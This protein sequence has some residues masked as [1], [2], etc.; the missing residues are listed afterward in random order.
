MTE[1]IVFFKV[2]LF[3][4][5]LGFG[6]TCLLAKPFNNKFTFIFVTAPCIGYSTIAIMCVFPL[7][8]IKNGSITYNVQNWQIY[9]YNIL[10]GLSGLIGICYTLYI[11]L[12]KKQPF[13]LAFLRVN[14]GLVAMIFILVYIYININ[15]FHNGFFSQNV[16]PDAAAYLSSADWIAKNGT[17]TLISDGYAHEV[18]VNALRWGFPS[19]LSI[20]SLVLHI[21]VSQVIFPLVII[22]FSSCIGLM[23]LLMTDALS[24]SHKKLMPIILVA[25]LLNGSLLAFLGESFY[26]FVISIGYFSVF[27]SL[28]QHSVKSHKHILFIGAICT[29]TCVSTSSE[30][31]CLCVVLIFGIVLYNYIKC[32]RITANNLYLVF[33][34]ILGLILV[35]P[36]SYKIFGFTAANSANFNNIGYP[37]PSWFSPS[38]IIGLTN[39]YFHSSEYLNSA[40][41]I[42]N[43]IMRSIPDIVINLLFSMFVVFELFKW[44]KNVLFIVSL[45]I[46]ISVFCLDVYLIQYRHY[47]PY[48]Y[49]YDK[50]VIAFAPIFIA[51][52][53]ISIDKSKKYPNIKFVISLL[54]IF[55]SSALFFHDRKATVS[56]VDIDSLNLIKMKLLGK[57]AVIFTDS[58]GSRNGY[59]IGKFRYIDRSADI[60]SEVI[61]GRN[62][63]D[64]WTINCLNYPQN[65]EVY[66]IVKKS[67]FIISNQNTIA[68]YRRELILETR[69][70]YLFNTGRKL[71]DLMVGDKNVNLKKIYAHYNEP[72]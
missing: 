72:Y 48:N 3:L 63:C 21:S 59:M 23:S 15:P 34:V 10:I 32:C 19:C 9:Y 33:A 54:L 66:L 65:S 14:I 36:L 35:Y 24:L 2:Y 28:S 70:Y 27:A 68:N 69:S 11:S 39:V 5:T 8:Y 29:A 56:Y 49:L 61:L 62:I 60:L 13:N 22:I 55:L 20:L 67:N 50:I 43:P 64:S 17:L 52:F 53:F 1:L 44:R 7:N 46:V 18:L 41:G 4:F 37:Q 6:L 31:F 16:G 25:I 12:V 57:E 51:F 47:G 30:L 42:P 45:I 40:T 26:P 71:S 58:R 38:E